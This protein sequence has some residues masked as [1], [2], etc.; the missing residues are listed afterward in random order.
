MGPHFC[1]LLDASGDRKT[2]TLLSFQLAKKT[3]QNKKTEP[4]STN[5][6]TLDTEN[7]KEK[8]IMTL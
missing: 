7:M 4:V 8:H 1:R 5:K 6:Q 3:K 2:I